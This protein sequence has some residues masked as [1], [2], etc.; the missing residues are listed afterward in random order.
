MSLPQTRIR[1]FS[2]ESMKGVQGQMQQIEDH[3]PYYA[4][5]P[6]EALHRIDERDGVA[7]VYP[8]YV[9]IIESSYNLKPA[10]LSIERWA[11]TTQGTD[12]KPMFANPKYAG[13]IITNITRGSGH[14]GSISI[15][16]FAKHEPEEIN[17]ELFNRLLMPE[18][19][20]YEKA[21]VPEEHL[22]A[23]RR[24]NPE[25]TKR[26]K[27]QGGLNLRQ[28]YVEAALSQNIAPHH[29][30]ALLEIQTAINRFRDFAIAQLSESDRHIQDRQTSGKGTYDDRDRRW[31]WLL[32]PEYTMTVDAASKQPMVTVNVPQQQ[33]IA[34]PVEDI[35][36]G[37]CAECGELIAVTARKCRYCGAS[38]APPVADETITRVNELLAAERKPTRKTLE[39]KQAEARERNGK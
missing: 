38:F 33:M 21:D 13:D 37:P 5:T 11:F 8:H 14:L 1:S 36:R 16:A 26:A 23:W 34:T 3:G 20:W 4:Y 7:H 28:S 35:Q 32:G 30:A 15:Q 6:G 18:P 12:G 24:R 27:E 19:V 25:L 2:E 17:L 22:G 39:Q 9:R 10:E 29:F 31:Q